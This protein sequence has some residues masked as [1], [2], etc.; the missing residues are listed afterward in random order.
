MKSLI[1]KVNLTIILVLVVLGITCPNVYSRTYCII[2]FILYNILFIAF[3]RHKK[4]KNLFNFEMVFISIFILTSYIYPVFLYDESEPFIYFF[5][6]PFDVNVISKAVFAST[7]AGSLFIMGAYKNPNYNLN[8]LKY[9]F[10]YSPWLLFFIDAVLIILFYLVGG[11]DYYIN[12]YTKSS[13]ILSGYD[14]AFQLLA[15]VQCTSIVLISI[16]YFLDYKHNNKKGF[17]IVTFILLLTFTTFT[18]LSG[19]RTTGLLILCPIIYILTQKY[20]PLNYLKFTFII[21][22]GILL[23][24]SIQIIRE[25]GDFD[26]TGITFAKSISDMLIPSRSNYLVYEVISKDGYTYGVTEL[27]GLFNVIPSLNSLFTSMGFHFVGSPTYFTNYTSNMFYVTTG[28]GTTLQADLILAFGWFG[29]IFFYF[30]GKWSNKLRVDTEQ[31][32]IKSTL[33]YLCF[34]ALCIYQIRSEA[35]YGI[36]LVVWSL[37]IG[38]SIFK[39]AKTKQRY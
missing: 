26:F 22:V 2:N 39:T 12:F 37:I 21:I 16:I 38:Y 11:F 27:Q 28:L 25:G 3:I 6:N 20:Y 36:R 29:L 24:F 5:G 15:L 34:M 33:L 23:M 31:G 17:T 18:T 35:S 14:A 9:Y 32:D 4:Y 7:V 10:R 30:L 13:K 8:T 19:N 1:N